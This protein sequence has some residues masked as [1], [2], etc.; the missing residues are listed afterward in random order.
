MRKP[1]VVIVLGKSG[2]GKGTQAKLLMKKFGLGYICTG[3]LLRARS[4]KKD[5]TGKKLSKSLLAGEIIPTPVVFKLWLDKAE[6]LKAKKGLNG[7]VMDGCPRKILEAYLDDEAFKWYEWDKNV[8]A[9]LV[10]ISDKEAIWRLTKRRICKD[11]KELIPFVGHFRKL[12]KCPKCGGKLI[13]RSDDTIK[14][15]RK[16]LG[17]FKIDVQPVV[18]Y[19][20]ET[21]RLF[22]VNGEQSIEDVFRDILKVVK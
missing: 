4:K 6:E 17:W 2:S 5:F 15:V 22:K 1:L 9:I 3:D 18:N 10:D 21:G 8:K 13:Q 16:R 14:A 11:C 7:F 12:K 20:R 19:Y